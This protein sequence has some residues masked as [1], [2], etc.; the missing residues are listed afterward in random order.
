[1]PKEIKSYLKQ[2][3]CKY[4]TYLSQFIAEDRDHEKEE[5]K[6]L[7]RRKQKLHIRSGDGKTAV[8][9]KKQMQVGNIEKAK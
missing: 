7:E 2:N 6:K 4:Y 1:M 3:L 5:R 9:I 8:C